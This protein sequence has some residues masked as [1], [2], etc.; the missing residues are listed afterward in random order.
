MA[1]LGAW[2]AASLAGLFL[3]AVIAA[4][5]GFALSAVALGIAAILVVILAVVVL[6]FGSRRGAAGLV[7]LLMVIAGI[8]LLN[9]IAAPAPAP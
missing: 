4:L 6:A 3:G 9:A 8:Y 7:L 1:G 5:T 2:L